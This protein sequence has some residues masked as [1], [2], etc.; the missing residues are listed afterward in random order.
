MDEIETFKRRYL[1]TL[2]EV[3]SFANS[4][5]IWLPIIVDRLTQKPTGT[6]IFNLGDHLSD[7]FQGNVVKGRSQST[8]SGGGAAW[9]CLVTWYLNFIF[10][11][12][13]II[14]AR[15]NKKFIPSAIS[16]CITVTIANNSTNTE[17]DILIFSLPQTLHPPFENLEGLNQLLASRLSEI[18]LTIV[19][20]KTNWNDNSQIPML[21]DLIYN[22]E[23]RLTHVS[24]GIE[25]VSPSSLRQF[26]YA[27]ATVPTN[28]R[29]KLKST[30]IH[31][32]RVKN[33]T[34]GNYWGHESKPEIASSIKELPTRSFPSF[35]QGGV[36]HHIDLQLKKNPDILQEFL[37]LEW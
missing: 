31:V 11:G 8:L 13:P 21:W 14:V 24:V 34:G 20:C 3:N 35:F 30:S 27:F 5:P 6:E 32:S 26:K 10:W 18:D 1:N 12:T 29:N 17:S 28:K 4:W 16:N 23:S 9:E 7:T 36:I 37:N 22:S 25:G 15:N 2:S 19:Q 33:L